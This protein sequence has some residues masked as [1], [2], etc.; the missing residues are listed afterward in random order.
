M[1]PFL[2]PLCA[3]CGGGGNAA[4]HDAGVAYGLDGG[5]NVPGLVDASYLYRDA[6]HK[7]ADAGATD[8]EQVG[9]GDGKLQSG[10]A[11]DDGNDLGG[12]GCSADCTSVER[13]FACPT[14]GS[15]CVSTIKC[16][17][18]RI[19]GKETCDDGN[20]DGADGC[21]ADCQIAPGYLC[22]PA[23]QRCVAAK[24]GDGIVAG[25]EACDD[26]NDAAADGCSDACMIETG[27]ACPTAGK[28]CHKTVCN[29]GVREGTEPCDDG[30][31]VVGDGCTPFCEVEPDCSAGACHS[32]CGD[33]LMLPD[34]H[35][36][37]DDGNTKDHDGC[38]ADCK[39]EAGYQCELQTGM[40][41]DTLAVP[42][43]Y[44]DFISLPASGAMRHP[45]FEKFHGDYAT[46]NL[47]MP[48]LD[49]KGK[50]HWSGICGAASAPYPSTDPKTGTCPY[51][52]QMTTAANFDQ[53]Y[54]DVPGVNVS[55]VT[56]MML[57]YDSA[58]HVYKINTGAFYPWDNDAHSW[59]AQGKET[60]KSVNS[61][62]HNFGFTSEV[63]T[64]F[65]FHLDAARPQL[66]SFDGD[67]D[68]WVFINRKLAVDIGGL[69]Q[70]RNGK[71]T[72]DSATA[73]K[74]GLEE[75]KI[76]EMALFHAERHTS[77]SNF[78]L[79]LDG[80]V[81]THSTCAAK[82]GDG[83][84]AGAEACDDGK[85]D[86]SYGSCT[87]SCQRAAF[88]GDGMVQG[89]ES[90]D[91]GVNLTTYST[92]GSAGCAPGCKPSAY[93]GDAHV[94]STSGEECDDG[95][96][97]GGYNHCGSDCRR[98]PRCGDGVIQSGDGENCD[99]GNLISN[100]GCSSS[101]R[102]EGPQ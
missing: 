98:G 68:V 26:G 15:A 20:T 88:C 69:H 56:R 51:N 19:S 11:C 83:I 67:D 52:Q 28:A 78:N 13:D 84:V 29:D 17:D 47:V 1:L 94:D 33:G 36:E 45:D 25:V 96:N 23:G 48:A 62:G 99:D 38:S 6:G 53:W 2:L 100:D 97:P 32:R 8:A 60:L 87:S 39:I 12:D 18:G 22:A 35:E 3:A 81:T 46:P 41:P 79:T 75:G 91:D 43:T 30:N 58:A 90:C 49:D 64:Y 70:S 5:E 59:V 37:C 55:K 101:C 7:L 85:N 34:D 71:V 73:T 40:L 102:L 54:N 95:A 24:C 66:L 21:G 86:G 27:F 42:V 72:L 92:N 93:C 57:A 50:P 14:P 9:C 44:R 63:R 80:F 89:P 31:Q 61:V 82:C 16:G 65:E 76:Y 4:G 77:A 10:E 74:L